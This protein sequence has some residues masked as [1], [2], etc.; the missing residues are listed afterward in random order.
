MR[1]LGAALL[2]FVWLAPPARAAELDWRAPAACPD[3]DELRFRIERAIAMPLRHAAALRFVIEVQAAQPG[4]TAH[5][6]I[7]GTS[8]RRRTLTAAGCSELADMVT[9]SVALALGVGGSFTA[10]Q[11]PPAVAPPP[12]G[13]SRTPQHTRA[14]ASATA[15]QQPAADAIP[16]GDEPRAAAGWSPGFSLW[17]LGDT[18]SLPQPG[19][20]FALAA[21]V[22]RAH[23]RVRATGSWY[24]EQREALSGVAVPAPAAELRLMTGTLSLCAAPSSG[25]EPR[26]LGFG[27]VGWELG[28]LSGEGMRVQRPRAGAALWS[29]PQLD[30]GASLALGATSLRLAAMFSLVV[31]LARENFV[32]GELGAVHRPPN[33]VGRAALGLEWTPR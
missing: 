32:L 19:A 18:G 4:Y 8:G 28:R 31:P 14:E 24:F 30:A 10:D 7:A 1:L 15:M 6:D 26:L 23:L 13:Q 27:C 33:V 5:V 22:Q 12:A 11:A 2:S 17:L 16:S 25:S 3:A 9:V 29:A 20:A 21:H